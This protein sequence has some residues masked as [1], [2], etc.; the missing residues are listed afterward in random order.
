MA[1]N[2]LCTHQ[3]L[4]F[5]SY[6]FIVINNALIQIIRNQIATFKNAKVFFQLFGA[7]YCSKCYSPLKQ[8]FFSIYLSKRSQ[9][10]THNNLT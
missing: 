3:I 7:L 8:T 1:S 4:R 9:K 5:L 10:R 6:T 2:T